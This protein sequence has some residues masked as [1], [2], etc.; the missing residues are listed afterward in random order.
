VDVLTFYPLEGEHG[1]EACLEITERPK[2][3]VM[4]RYGLIEDRTTGRLTPVGGVA[5]AAAAAVPAGDGGS[6]RVIEYW[7]DEYF[8]CVVDGH[9]AKRGRHGYG[10]APYSLAYGDQTPSRDPA[11]A[12]ASMLA[13]MLYLVPL[14]DRLI[15]MKQNAVHLYAYPAPKLT[16]CASWENSIGDNGRPRPIEFRPGHIF[17]LYPGEDL[18]FLQWTGTPPDLEEVIALTRSLI[19]QAGVPSVLFGLPPT[20]SA[21]GYLLNQLINAARV[22]F[23]QISRHA[24][25]AL[26][27]VVALLW[28]LVEQRIGET[29]Y[30]HAG[31]T[32]GGWLG[33]SPKDIGGYYGC[34]VQVRALAPADTIAEGS[35]AAGMVNAKLASRRWA[36]QEK[37]GI[38]NP[39]AMQD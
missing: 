6:V 8:A 22:S 1:L 4:Q 16:G 14:L 26:E 29:V 35:F 34:R 27:R 10:Q 39:D 9:V 19:E 3:L 12:S 30:V 24:E 23:N 36:M 18:S 11:K 7:D 13:P 17:P 32:A 25:R 33:L 37:L 28:R 21:S 2:R 5:S 15:T 38:A 20:G 31:A